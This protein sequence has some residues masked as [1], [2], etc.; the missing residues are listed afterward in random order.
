M[1]T[2][3]FFEFLEIRNFCEF[4][5]Y[6]GVLGIFSSAFYGEAPKF[7]KIWKFLKSIFS[8][9]HKKSMQAIEIFISLPYCIT[10]LHFFGTSTWLLLLR[11]VGNQ[12]VI[13][14]RWINISF[15][16]ILKI[17]RNIVDLDRNRKNAWFPVAPCYIFEQ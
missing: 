5:V 8:L 9:W 7:P 2:W 17:R 16:L 15:V 1:V 14:E 12:T 4:L 11:N 3:N 10:T 6:F 13:F